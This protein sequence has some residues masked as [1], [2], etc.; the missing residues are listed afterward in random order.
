[1]QTG[2]IQPTLGNWYY[3]NTYG[4]MERSWILVDGRWY[5]MDD[6]GRMQTGWL[7][8]NGNW[9]FLHSDGAMAVGTVIDGWAI[10]ADG[11]ARKEGAV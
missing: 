10:G 2:W 11:I 7:M 8:Y 5:Y 9:Y 6:S 1:M 4:Y 3:L